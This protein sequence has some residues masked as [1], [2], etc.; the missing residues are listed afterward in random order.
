MCTLN[1][2]A[3]INDSRHT[4]KGDSTCIGYLCNKIILFNGL[5]NRH[6]RRLSV[7]LLQHFT[8]H[9][10]KP[11]QNTENHKIHV[12]FNTPSSCS[13]LLDMLYCL[14]QFIQILSKINYKLQRHAAKHYRPVPHFIRIMHRL[15]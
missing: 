7:R 2:A 13:V 5:F 12:I 15:K 8:T 1:T 11:C 4:I 3:N 9:I 14:F 10:C 6:Q